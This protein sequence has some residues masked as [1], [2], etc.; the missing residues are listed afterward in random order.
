MFV[1]ERYSHIAIHLHS[2]TTTQTQTDARN[3]QIRSRLRLL[4][5]SLKTHH[6]NMQPLTPLLLVL[7]A[8]AAAHQTAA[9]A[10]VEHSLDLGSTFATAGHIHLND[11]DAAGAVF[12]REPFTSSQLSQLQQLVESDR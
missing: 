9:S 10:L 6:N 4:L 11:G 8:S 5:R 7:L 2:P 1:V 12:E 3:F